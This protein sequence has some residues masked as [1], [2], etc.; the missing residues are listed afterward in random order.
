[1]LNLNII[2][3][4]FARNRGFDATILFDLNFIAAITTANAEKC[5]FMR[6]FIKQVGLGRSGRDPRMALSSE[7]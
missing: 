6:F 5:H 2:F 3:R 7:R 1:M 4:I